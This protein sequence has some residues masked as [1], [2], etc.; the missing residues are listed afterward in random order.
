[1][2]SKTS[3]SSQPQLQAAQYHVDLYPPHS[4]LLIRPSKLRRR[5]RF[6]RGLNTFIRRNHRNPV[7][8]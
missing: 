2:P 8:A 4:S 3:K 6:F 1:M 5:Q 7:P